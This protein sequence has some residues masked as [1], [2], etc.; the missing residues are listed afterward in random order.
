MKKRLGEVYWANSQK[1]DKMDNK[2]RR[3]YAVTKDNGRNVGVS[4]IRG[5][6]DNPK[7]I[8]RLFELDM[9]RYPLSKRS[10]VDK[11]VYT[12]R[13]NKKP[14]RLED[15]DIFDSSP[16]FKLNSR[17]TH[18]VLVHTGQTSNSQKKGRKH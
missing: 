12:R 18:D 9:S 2:K 14:L 10:G 6:N 3:Q 5:F 4:K 8:E 1:I 15:F 11:K 16:A 7:N 17:D 13:T